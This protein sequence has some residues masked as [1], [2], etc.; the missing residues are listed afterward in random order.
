MRTAPPGILPVI[1]VDR[2][3]PKPLYRQLYEGYRNA[4]VE[5]QLRARQ[6]LPSTRSLAT[7]LQVSRI[8]ILNAFEQLRAEGYLEGRIGSGTYVAKSLPDDLLAPV[9]RSA[10]Q[11]PAN[12]PSRRVI[13]RRVEILLPGKAGPWL[14][15]SGVFHIGQPP[16]DRFPVQAWSRL[17]VRHSRNPDVSLLHYGHRMGFAPLREA[18][19]EYLRTARAVRCEAEQIMIVSGSQQALAL[20]SHVLLDPGSAVWVEEPGYFGARHVLNLAGARLVPV[21]VDDE[22]LDVSAGIDRCPRPRAAFVTPSHQ[23]PL[24]ATMSA[25]RRLQLLDWAR[26]SNS[27]II[28]DDYDS[29]YRYGNLPIASL[30]GLDRDS[31][32]IYVGTFTKILFPALRLAYVVLPPDLVA[33]F[34][35]ARRAM[36]V[37]SPTFSQVVLTDFIR[38][39]HFARHIRKMRLLCRERR[40][41]LVNALR[42]ELGALVVLGDQ[43]GMYLTVALP[44]GVRDREICERA[45]QEGLRVAPLSECYLGKADRQG[46]ILGYGGTSV[47]EI[48]LGVRKL[49]N[50][51]RSGSVPRRLNKSGRT[52]RS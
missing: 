8:P 15:D 27:W 39:G 28:E 37:C 20:S 38:E 4:I 40:T 19:A 41:A 5:R 35:E 7:E 32:V 25:S 14:R 45:A 16:L 26:R 22:G 1:A 43:A 9:R 30:Q 33:A 6:R 12:R 46:L 11:K 17:V 29:E 44:E 49:R 3:S 31:R 36:D 50:I 2:K 13:A 23:F 47:E 42:R 18:I 10:S 48:E 51:V 21:P 24:G 34:V 52:Q